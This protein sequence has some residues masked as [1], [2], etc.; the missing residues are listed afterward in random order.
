MG[1]E[2]SSEVSDVTLPRKA[3]VEYTLPYLKPTQVV[4]ASSLR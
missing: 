3:S 4:E 2:V 1:S